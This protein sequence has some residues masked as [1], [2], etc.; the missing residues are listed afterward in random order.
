MGWKKGKAAGGD[1]RRSLPPAPQWLKNKNKNE[2]ILK[3]MEMMDELDLDISVDPDDEDEE[4][5]P[6]V[7]DTTE[8]IKTEL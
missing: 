2:L 4:D 1:R 8:E 3:V 5:A 7:A 6:F